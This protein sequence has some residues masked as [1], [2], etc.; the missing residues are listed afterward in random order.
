MNVLLAIII[1]TSTSI[2]SCN[3]AAVVSTARSASVDEQ[4][5]SSGDVKAKY[6]VGTLKN[7]STVNISSD[8]SI[9]DTYADL[10]TVKSFKVTASDSDGNEIPPEDINGDVTF[11]IVVGTISNTSNIGVI[12]LDS[13][14]DELDRLSGDNLTF[15]INESG[16][17]V[18]SFDTKYLNA[19]F[20]ITNNTPSNAVASA[21]THA[22]T[23]IAFTD[24][25]T[26]NGEIQGAVNITKASDESDITHYVLYWGSNTTTAQ[27]AT[28]ISTIAKTG[29][30]LT[31]TFSAD[32]AVP[33]GATHLLVFSKNATG[34][35][36][37][38]VNIAI[39][40]VSVPTN[41][42]VSVSFTDTDN[43]ANELQGTI[44]ITK[45]TT[46]SDVTHYV[47]YW[48]SDA[49]TKQSA[50]PLDTIAVTGA[51]VTSTLAANTAL[52][53]GATHLLVFTKNANGEILTGINLAIIDNYGP[54][55]APVSV[56]FTDSDADGS[57]LQ[58]AV[59]IAKAADESDVTHYVLYW[60]SNTTTKQS[61]TAIDTIVKTGAN[62][63]HTF[64]ANTAV[65]SGA[66]HLL[67]FTKNADG[68]MATGVNVAITDVGIP[69]N[70]S[71]G[72]S[73]TDSD[74]TSGEIQGTVTITKA[75]DESDVT[76]YVL[77]WGSSTTVKQSGTPIDTI[78]VTGSNVTSTIAA[79]TAIPGGATHLLVFT[80]NTD[81]EMAAG[82]NVAITDVAVPT[83]ASAGVSFTDSDTTSGE[84]Q[85]TVTITKAADESDVTHYVLYWGSNSTTAQSATPIETIA[86]TGANV[87]STIAADTAI[88]G[89]ATHLLVFTKNAN[90][91]MLTGVN[92]VITDVAIPTN[93]SASVSFTDSDTTS[94][95]IQ[96]T[97]T[98]TK[99]ADESDV[100]HYVL[101][102]GSDTT[103]KQSGTP[104]ETI[105]KTGANVT[106][107]I[108]ADTAIPGGATHLLVFTKNAI[109]EMATGVNV[110]ITDVAVPTNASA[111]VSFT[112][113]D[114]SAGEI[115]GTVTI[116]L[117]ADESDVT[118]YVLYWGSNT[119]TKQSGTPIE[120]IAK[121]GANVTSTIAADTAIPGGATH[122]L[123][124][125]KNANGEM[126]TGVN[127]AI[128]D[129]AVP[130]NAS[131]GVSFTDGDFN[132]GEIQGDVTITKATDESDVTHYVLYWGSST[133]V[134]QSAT[135]VDTIIKTGSDV[136]HTFAADTAIPGGATHLLVFT[137][138]AN[139]EMPT[140][141]N[142]TLTD[143]AGPTNA[144]AGVSFTDSDPTVGEIQGTVTIT[145]ATDE[146]DVTHYVLY[147]GSSTTV[148]QSATP[149]DT[150]IKT[151][152]D[153]THTFAA[154]TA[155]PGGATH[156]LVFT[157][158]AGGEMTAGVSTGITE[159][160]GGKI[161]PASVTF[162]DYDYDSAEIWGTVYI[163]RAANEKD[164]VSY[165]LYW[166]SDAIT[167]NSGTPISTISKTG[168]NLTYN[169]SED[170]AIPAGS[171]HLLVYTK[172]ADI[173]SDRPTAVLLA[174][175][176]GEATIRLETNTSNRL[177]D[178]IPK[179]TVAGGTTGDSI[180]LYYGATCDTLIETKTKAAK[181]V[182]FNVTLAGA[183]AYTF[184]TKNIT[185]GVCSS[186][187]TS[188]TY[189][190]F[191][192]MVSVV[193]NGYAF[194]A[195]RSDGSVN[196][197]GDSDKGGDSTSAAA[198]IDGTIDVTTIYPGNSA[199]AALRSDGSVITWGYATSGGDSSAVA[200]NLDGTIAVTS[201]VP[202][203]Y[204]FAA[205]RSD[206]SVITWGMASNGGDSSSV[207]SSID[208]TIDVTDIS[209][210]V[211]ALAALRSDG[212]V[213]TWGY[214][215]YGADSSSV[216]A[217]ID[218]T[219][220][221]TA[222]FANDR[223]FAALRSDGSV[224]TWGYTGYG[225]DSSSVASDIDGTIDV[226][227]IFN[228]SYA[229]AALRSDGSVITWGDSSKGGDSS[230][231]SAALDG[232]TA[233]T[234]I[235]ATGSAFAAIRSDGSV[236]TWGEG[237]KGGNSSGVASLIDGTIDVSA[238]YGTSYGDFAALRVDGSV[239]T[240]GESLIS[241][242]VPGLDGTV[243]AT[244]IANTSY[245]FAAI[246]ADG[247]VISWGVDY[248][249]DDGPT[250]VPSSL[251]GT[252]DVT[253]I[254]GSV[255]A[256]AALR[257]DGTVVS[258]GDPEF[259]AVKTPSTPTDID[260][261]NPVT[262]IHGN[263]SNAFASIHSD[264]SVTTWG[265]STM[266]GDSSSVSSELDGTIDVV[267]ISSNA[268][269]F[270]ALRTDGSVVTWGWNT[271]GGDSSSVAAALNGT[272]D[273]IEIFSTERAFAALRADGSVITW[274]YSSYGGSSS[275]VAADID[276]TIPIIAVYPATQSFA[277]LRDDGSV[278]TW[279][280]SSYGG[281][282]SS[283][284]SD[285]DGT[286]KVTAI[287]AASQAFAALRVDG[288]VITWGRTGG[289]GGDSSAVSSAINGDNDVVAL[290]STNRVFVAL[291]VDG[292]VITWGS[293]SYGGD[294]SSVASAIDGS[295]DVIS[296]SSTGYAIAALR[297]DGSVIT[298]GSSSLGG[299]SSSV[300]SSLDGTIKSVAIV[301]SGR[302]FAALRE[303]GSVITWGTSTYGGNSSSVSSKIDGTIDVTSIYSND[304]AFA[305]LR[306]DGSVITWGGSTYGGDSSG[307]SQSILT[308]V[309]DLQGGIDSF[310]AV[311]ESGSAI[312]W[313]TISPF[314]EPILQQ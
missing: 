47:L 215:A 26:S 260:G 271:Y 88:P 178:V 225:S 253:A 249:N 81:G 252:I 70:A 203:G 308:G 168:S 273:V 20:I 272:T 267:T 131:A 286:I 210:T 105:A 52:P 172:D 188:Y 110:A 282:S 153:V 13:N 187:T 276:G 313:E 247:S 34:E 116:T 39:T 274:G 306:A 145:K 174:D 251:D 223:A 158:N 119:T 236:I 98:I 132:S 71:A 222:V 96:G 305:A 139:G 284:S 232:T 27:S 181:V 269:A 61:T 197:W 160:T 22:A 151:G 183:G 202:V 220:P 312:S 43:D 93:T 154:D 219:I 201:V 109:G 146:S 66:T 15:T 164:V 190:S 87:T 254:S 118:H 211:N 194:A 1:L 240:W 101:Y 176:Q 173:E 291:R 200:S 285:I 62:V 311:S 77:Y 295:N 289:F 208:G 7:G 56:S 55:N 136:T 171:T 133:T 86:K 38:G 72:I 144:A 179:V 309:V 243:S 257:T 80:K 142:T 73:F 63:T 42:A 275:S 261:T 48:G 149:I 21:P 84:I 230:S 11:D 138:N 59:T 104:I 58:G 224:V 67:A 79:D 296:I 135:P 283:V 290:Y 242:I 97:V 217:A 69:V 78:A 270:A 196:T 75:A 231:V 189:E 35:M 221:V 113:S 29:S 41:A 279:G 304:Q 214:G 124:F 288:S 53:G 40:D 121:T 238:I 204:A 120:T 45:A 143:V 182:I 177:R 46:E 293:T 287:Q 281:D 258:W 228:N 280:D 314:I 12:I 115:Q 229:F 16:K 127:A 264:G 186:N 180:A 199:F 51:N 102:W 14:G 157:K 31:Y 117:A 83:N 122:L 184:S 300:A 255:N 123:V 169:F 262:S 299:D 165:L 192:P 193:S 302:A 156:L 130:T 126:L 233:V 103:T 263:K 44:T 92:A 2:S 76:H 303:D 30:N 292:S 111:G 141:V 148:K 54:L 60:G 68:E 57:Q 307:I 198:D 128:T 19:T 8:T 6:P 100:T 216:A 112:D 9:P 25:D 167:K 24:S 266:G 212:S 205:I 163:R 248:S 310:C 64:G 95:E 28:P 85:G 213:V 152:S 259:G 244:S 125:T 297:A 227:T 147:W 129:V 99:A 155:I 278:I 49:S 37:T 5:D 134:K 170:T 256:F 265:D 237:F 250:T 226:T 10:D 107:T 137:K 33:S 74:T 218:G 18:V 161:Y 207:S 159:M 23:S 114:T 36:A 32:T 195:I 140:G 94:G 294:S 166:G 65:P 246:R 209:T 241:G 91:E 89:G 234:S 175:A 191:T 301:G 90:G 106:S 82:V 4:T 268:W 206:G 245:V 3:K 162:V 108:A 298:W 235:S 150:I 277:A 239:I 185:S 50:T 17:T